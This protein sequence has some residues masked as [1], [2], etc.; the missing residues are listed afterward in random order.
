MTKIAIQRRLQLASYVSSSKDVQSEQTVI[1][2]C[3]SVLKEKIEKDSVVSTQ[4]SIHKEERRLGTDYTIQEDPEMHNTG[5]NQ[6]VTL[7]HVPLQ[8]K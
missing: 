2:E 4:K 7:E 3:L 8:K 5:Q 6:R 1:P